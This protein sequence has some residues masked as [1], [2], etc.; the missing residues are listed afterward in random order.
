MKTR[1]ALALAA[2]LAA[3]CD[4]PSSID[5]YTDP[6]RLEFSARNSQASPPPAEPELAFTGGD[7]E[8]V[9]EA[10]LS[11]ANPCQD[12]EADAISMGGR[13]L[14][15]AVRVRQRQVPCAA[16]VG[17]FEY[18]ARLLE[19]PPGTYDVSV[20]HEYPGSDRGLFRHETQVTV[21]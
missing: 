1:I 9:V 16:V 19:L 21:R 20:A 11:A 6:V 4:M 15:L 18:T 8:I 3:G 12:I 14:E 10:R 2:L 13:R 5:D 17:G 7:G